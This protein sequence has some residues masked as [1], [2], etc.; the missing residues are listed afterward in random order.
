[1]DE[2]LT[3]KF[4]FI[5]GDEKHNFSNEIINVILPGFNIGIMEL[6]TITREI[7][8]LGDSLTFNDMIITFRAD[9]E[10]NNYKYF[11]KQML[12]IGRNKDNPEYE[13]IFK[14][15]TINILDKKSNP[16]IGLSLGNIFPYYISDFSLS[17]QAVAAITFDVSFKINNLDII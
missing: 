6:H 10:L 3:N 13:Y 5:T 12:E 7:S 15:C 4:E 14:D 11:F 1:M 2:L 16:I 8:Y 9:K 17:V